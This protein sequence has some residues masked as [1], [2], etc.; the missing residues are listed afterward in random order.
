MWWTVPRAEGDD[1]VVLYTLREALLVRVKAG[2]EE[3]RPALQA[4][5]DMVIESADE[6]PEEHRRAV[7]Q[8]RSR[9]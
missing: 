4:V 6:G 1:L 3:A 5:E 2:E 9:Q 8:A 7:E